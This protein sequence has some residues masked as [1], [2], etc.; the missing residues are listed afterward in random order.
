MIVRL[1][2]PN[3]LNTWTCSS[4]SSNIDKNRKIFCYFQE[5]GL[6]CSLNYSWQLMIQTLEKEKTTYIVEIIYLNRVSGIIH[7]LIQIDVI[8]NEESWQIKQSITFWNDTIDSI[9][10]PVESK[11]GK[12]LLNTDLSAKNCSTSVLFVCL[13]LLPPGMI[14]S[15][16]RVRIHWLHSMFPRRWGCPAESLS[17]WRLIW[18][19]WWK[20]LHILSC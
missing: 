13:K 19:R 16:C 1:L 3:T 15:C 8:L 6:N 7:S 12:L 4:S 10:S 14:L 5:K 11:S 18:W 2:V 20:H 9:Y 17:Q